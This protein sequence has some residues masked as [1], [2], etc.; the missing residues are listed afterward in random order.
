MGYTPDD[1]Q[2]GIALKA[3]AGSLAGTG[4][5]GRHSGGG[6]LR[7]QNFGGKVGIVGYCCGGL[8]SWRA[9][10]LVKGLSAAVP[11][12]RRWHHQ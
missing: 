6:G 7:R 12:L 2:A 1:M 9:A 8:L 5:D 4:C 10:A 11:V 3:A